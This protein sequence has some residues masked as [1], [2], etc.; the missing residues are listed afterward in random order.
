VDGKVASWYPV[1]VLA[2]PV[3]KTSS[4]F[5]RPLSYLVL[6]EINNINGAREVK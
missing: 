6:I 3:S 4:S 2:L 5:L 1:A